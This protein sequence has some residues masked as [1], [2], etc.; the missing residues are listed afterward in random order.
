MTRMRRFLFKEEKVVIRG[1]WFGDNI[2]Y[3]MFGGRIN[4][5]RNL[6][7]VGGALKWH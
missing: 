3:L 4:Y 7:R 2:F 1:T 5:G 6:V